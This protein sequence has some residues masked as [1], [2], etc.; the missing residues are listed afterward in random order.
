MYSKH[1]TEDVRPSPLVRSIGVQH[2]YTLP[3]LLMLRLLGCK[4]QL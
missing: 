4:A 3:G 2:L 1:L